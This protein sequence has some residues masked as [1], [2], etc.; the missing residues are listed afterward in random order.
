LKVQ[1]VSLGLTEADLEV[2]DIEI[3]WARVSKI[4]KI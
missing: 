3:F 1:C 4:G 2:G